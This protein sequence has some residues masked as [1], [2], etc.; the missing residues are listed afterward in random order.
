MIR[1]S[2]FLGRERM[3]WMG[4]YGLL[5]CPLRE[6]PFTIGF[7]SSENFVGYGR[8][9]RHMGVWWINLSKEGD[10]FCENK[11]TKDIPLTMSTSKKIEIFSGWEG[12]TTEAKG[13]CNRLI[14]ALKTWILTSINQTNGGRTTYIYHWTRFIS[15]KRSSVIPVFASPFTVWSDSMGMRGPSV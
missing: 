7:R 4:K 12:Q 1:E 9:G 8:R 6:Y 11:P 10:R 2:N 15:L 14:V 13:I 3:Y 5:G